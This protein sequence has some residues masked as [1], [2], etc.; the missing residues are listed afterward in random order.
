MSISLDQFSIRDLEELQSMVAEL[1][2]QKGDDSKTSIRLGKFKEEYLEHLRRIRGAKY[3]ESV[4]LSMSHLI[5]YFGKNCR[6]NEISVK[7]SES[8]FVWVRK[9]APRGFLTY[10]RDLKAAFNRAISWKYINRNPLEV[11]SLPKIQKRPRRAITDS[12]LELILNCA[13]NQYIKDVIVFARFTGC[14]RSEIVNL[15]WK[16]IDF[17]NKSILIGD[18]DFITKGYE[19]RSIPMH[20]KVF[21]LLKQLYSN[22]KKSKSI[23]EK[24]VFTKKD[25][26]PYHIDKVSYFFR[27]A[28]NKAG[29]PSDIKFHSLRHSFATSI[30]DKNISPFV[31]KELLGHKDIATTQL[32]VHT[33]NE[34]LINAVKAA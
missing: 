1:R 15:K 28:R 9:T 25:G 22:T 4:R 30:A 5:S 16:H 3:C 10:Y 18:D 6:L 12:E 34:S 11:I 14:R 31:L 33:S 29:L 8:F 7:E 19:S 13:S 26:F 20:E 17:T 32:Y 24:F 21:V 23:N 27:L 2:S